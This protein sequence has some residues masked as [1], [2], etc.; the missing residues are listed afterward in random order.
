[1]TKAFDQAVEHEKTIRD[2]Y[3]L[4]IE[5]GAYGRQDLFRLQEELRFAEQ[6]RKE[7][8]AYMD[9]LVVIGVLAGGVV[10]GAG[11]TGYVVAPKQPPAHP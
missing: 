3:A 9:Q 11:I 2:Y 1:M 6:A 8:T 4:A 7:M 5:Q 10:L